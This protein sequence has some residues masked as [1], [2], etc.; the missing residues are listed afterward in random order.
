MGKGCS[1]GKMEGSTMESIKMTKRKVTGNSPGLMAKSI[2]ANGRMASS[3]GEE[4]LRLQLG[5]RSVVYGRTGRE[6]PG[7][8]SEFINS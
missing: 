7:W 8:T 6:W 4:C 3:T 1:P 2:R 5:V